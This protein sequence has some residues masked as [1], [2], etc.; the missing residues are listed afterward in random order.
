MSWESFKLNPY[1]EKLAECVITF[2]EKVDSLLVSEDRVQ[3]E[4]RALETCQYKSSTFSDVLSRIQKTVDELNLHSYANLSQWVASLDKRIEERF[5][6][7]LQC[8]IASWTERL[9]TYA[10]QGTLAQESLA[11]TDT[12][13]SSGVVHKPG[14]DPEFNVSK[15]RNVP[16]CEW[17]CARVCGK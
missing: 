9:L 14:G 2:Q 7:R 5:A 15:S 1:V 12:T 11:D 17:L 16:L 10:S 4:L 3:K 13:V 8:G 6:V